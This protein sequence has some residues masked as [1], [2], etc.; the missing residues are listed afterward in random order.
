MHHKLKID[1]EFLEAKIKGDKLFEIRCNDRGYQ[2]G[3][4]AE[5]C[6]FN[7]RGVPEYYRY[8]ITYVIGYNQQPNWVVFGE[9]PIKEPQND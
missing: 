3:D 4:T 6:R 1:P 7:L 2:K 9:R 5:Y 8:E